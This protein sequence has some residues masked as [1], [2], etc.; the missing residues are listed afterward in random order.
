MIV[1]T[2]GLSDVIEGWDCMTFTAA[3]HQGAPWLCFWG[4]AMLFTF[5]HLMLTVQITE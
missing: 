3:Q 2:R 4:A 5:A 1:L